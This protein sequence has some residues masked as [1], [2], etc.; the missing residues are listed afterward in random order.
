M[1]IHET[2]LNI[3]K[4]FT[5]HVCINFEVNLVII[6]LKISNRYVTHGVRKASKHNERSVEMS[7]L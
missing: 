5:L 7:N 6:Q 1:V 3:V 4:Y 2:F